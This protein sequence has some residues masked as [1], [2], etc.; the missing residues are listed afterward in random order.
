M[1]DVNKVFV[2]ITPCRVDVVHLTLYNLTMEGRW[3]KF[4]DVDDVKD[5]ITS[6][7]EMLQVHC[8]RFNVISP[9]HH[10]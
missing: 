3:N 2:F 5:F 4:Y 10:Q 1:Y 7:W 8:V 6:N 9:L